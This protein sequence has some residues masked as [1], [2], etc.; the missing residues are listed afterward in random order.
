[1]SDI[2]WAEASG[3]MEADQDSQRFAR[4]KV[5]ASAYWPFLADSATPGEFTRRQALVS[6]EFR[7]VLARSVEAEHL[8]DIHSRVTAS[9]AADFDLVHGQRTAAAQ[10]K[11]AARQA[12]QAAVKTSRTAKAVYPKNLSEGDVL[13]NGNVVK[14]VHD[15][16]VGATV[17]RVTT[18]K[19]DVNLDPDKQY[20]VESKTSSRTALMLNADS[21]VKKV[22]GNHYTISDKAGN[23][24]AEMTFSPGDTMRP[25][26]TPVYED[27]EGQL[28]AMLMGMSKPA[29]DGA[30]SSSRTEGKQ[31]APFGGRTAARYT[32][33][34]GYAYSGDE[35]DLTYSVV[36]TGDMD[37]AVAAY[38]S[39]D[40][41]QAKADELNDY[42][43]PTNGSA[44]DLHAMS[45]RTAGLMGVYDDGIISVYDD[46][47]SQNSMPVWEGEADD[48]SQV[49]GIVGDAGFPIMGQIEHAPD[50]TYHFALGHTMTA[51]RKTSSAHAGLAQAVLAEHSTTYRT[52]TRQQQGQATTALLSAY[53]SSG[54]RDIYAFGERWV[55]EASL[56]AEAAAPGDVGFGSVYGGEEPSY[57]TPDG[58]VW[59]YRKGQRV[60]FY[61][62]QGEQ[63]GPE[64]SNVAP[65]AAY[66]M[67]QG[68]ESPGLSGLGPIGASKT[69]AP[70]NPYMQ[71][72]PGNP[73]LPV[74]QTPAAPAAMP[75]SSIPGHRAQDVDGDAQPDMA[76]DDGTMTNK[77]S[78]PSAGTGTMAAWRQPA[79]ETKALAQV[80]SK[81]NEIVGSLV[82]EQSM[83]VESA[84]IVAKQTV[85]NYPAMVS[86]MSSEM[87]TASLGQI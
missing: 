73:T 47:Q 18:D 6:G 60:R 59:M 43:G 39:R 45:S 69:A 50:D 2:M 71:S 11:N 26:I 72:G 34:D 4:A 38:Y 76:S 5:E 80:R 37:H 46:S 22:D 28:S 66:A 70:A 17:V 67:D 25:N 82:S 27:S 23:L 56:S 32:V 57:T 75:G 33:D 14:E 58:P 87:V 10:K 83:D 51:S 78:N 49:P 55:R 52:A 9:Q 36:D 30:K 35:G 41:A 15:T 64:Q 19:G 77:R 3:D 86:G 65:A 8:E 63:V 7:T 21:L 81:V 12:I 62:A 79:P 74:T 53:A 48:I 1:V 16:G 44:P 54:E 84:R 13:P 61:N 68:W 42:D 85:G 40:D 20:A 24:L 29:R 31:S